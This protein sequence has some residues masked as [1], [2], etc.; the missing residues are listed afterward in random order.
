MSSAMKGTEQ[1][2]LAAAIE[3]PQTRGFFFK[4]C[5]KDLFQS[6]HSREIFNVM[7]ELHKGEKIIDW[8]IIRDFCDEAVPGDYFSEM[9]ATMSGVYKPENWIREKVSLIKDTRAN[10]QILQQINDE[11]RT[12]RPDF[13]KYKEIIDGAKLID[14]PAEDHSWLAGWNK[15]INTERSPEKTSLSLGLP[16]LDRWIGG[17]KKGEILSILARTTIGKTWIALGILEQAL[18][19]KGEELYT[20]SQIGF[21]SFEMPTEA[22][23]QRQAQLY[24]GLWREDLSDQLDRGLDTEGFIKRHKEVKMYNR[25]YT[26]SDIK[27]I[28]VRDGLEIIFIDY[29]QLIQD[30]DP[31][32]KSYEKTTNKIRDLKLFAIDKKKIIILTVQLSR[33]GG[34]GGWI[35]VTIDSARESGQIEELSDFI[36]G[37][38]NPAL[39]PGLSDQDRVMMRETLKIELLKNKRGPGNNKVEANFS[40]KSGRI[41]EMSQREEE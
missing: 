4:N 31:K 11:A 23:V 14:L 18:K 17:F 35:P 33:S 25:A 9:L 20:P 10:R 15:F 26:V 7:S 40:G 1:A 19:L 2:L 30:E 22:I 32:L 6:V 12:P 36:I 28:S 5:D 27:D 8:T 29:L 13:K 16:T 39:N 37:A 38:W 21:F 24:F 3:W 41:T 34:G